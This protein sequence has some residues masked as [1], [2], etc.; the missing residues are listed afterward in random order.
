MKVILHQA[1]DLLPCQLIL[2]FSEPMI[3]IIILMMIKKIFFDQ[4]K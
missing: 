4:L 3:M 1:K 2:I